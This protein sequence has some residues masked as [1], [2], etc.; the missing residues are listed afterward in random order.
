[1]ELPIYLSSPLGFPRIADV[2]GTLH[3]AQSCVAHIPVPCRVITVCS[4][5]TCLNDLPSSGQQLAAGQSPVSTPVCLY[6][7]PTL[8]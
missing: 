4:V 1:M 6:R 2:S 7:N 3:T 5:C 8:R